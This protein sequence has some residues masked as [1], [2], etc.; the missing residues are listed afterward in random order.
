MHNPLYVALLIQRRM[1]T[2]QRDTWAIF[3]KGMMLPSYLHPFRETPYPWVVTSGLRMFSIRHALQ[4][5]EVYFIGTITQSNT[6]QPED[7]SPILLLRYH[8][9]LLF[10]GLYIIY[11]HIPVRVALEFSKASAHTTDTHITGTGLPPRPIGNEGALV[12]ATLATSME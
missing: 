9:K 10:S 11:H 7:S 3:P 12:I 6:S 8:P 2:L 5:T 4:E 1:L